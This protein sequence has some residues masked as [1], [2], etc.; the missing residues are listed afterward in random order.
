MQQR[1]ARVWHQSRPSADKLGNAY[2]RHG[3]LIGL[4]LPRRGL[5]ARIV[6]SRI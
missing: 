5:W 1:H 2:H 3:P 6:G 4:E